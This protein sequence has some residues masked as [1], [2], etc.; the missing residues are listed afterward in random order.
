M[1]QLAKLLISLVFLS[2]LSCQPVFKKQINQDLATNIVWYKT[3]GM[4]VTPPDINWKEGS[5]L[6]CNNNTG[7]ITIYE[8][9]GKSN[10]G[11]VAG[12]MY[13]DSWEAI[14][15][16]PA[17]AMFHE[18]AFGHEYGHAFLY[19][20]TGDPDNDHLTSFWKPGGLLETANKALQDQGL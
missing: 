12:A 18:V 8:L 20:T 19:L 14:I 3:Y 4:V 7:F 6:T 1:V 11:C 9:N 10:T 17:G 2:F 16:W 13:L 5:D 15:A